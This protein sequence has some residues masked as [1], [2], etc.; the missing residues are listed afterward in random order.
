MAK[1]DIKLDKPA[2]TK[3]IT[4]EISGDAVEVKSDTPSVK[5]VKK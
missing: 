2:V 3:Q 4:V 5:I 1:P